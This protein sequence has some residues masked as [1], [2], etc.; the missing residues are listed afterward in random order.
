M[1]SNQTIRNSTKSMQKK[2][3]SK[4]SKKVNLVHKEVQKEARIAE[5]KKKLADL[6][7]EIKTDDKISADLKNLEADYA[8]IAFCKENFQHLEKEFQELDLE[9]QN[10][11]VSNTFIDFGKKLY[12]LDLDI[13]NN[14][15][16]KISEF[17]VKIL[18][19][20][21]E[22]KKAFL[23]YE[24]IKNLEKKYSS[25]K[26]ALKSSE[27]CIQLRNLEKK[28]LEFEFEFGNSLE[29]VATENFLNLK[30]K[31]SAEL[32]RLKNIEH[33]ADIFDCA[34]YQLEYALIEESLNNL[35][36]EELEKKLLALKVYLAEKKTVSSYTV[37]AK[38]AK[39][40]LFKSCKAISEKY[41]YMSDSEIDIN[42]GS[43]AYFTVEDFGAIRFV[44]ANPTTNAIINTNTIPEIPPPNRIAFTIQAGKG[45]G[46]GKYDLPTQ[47]KELDCLL[48]KDES[49][50]V[51]KGA[52]ITLPAG[53]L[54]AR[55]NSVNS[56]SFKESVS[57]VL[58]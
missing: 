58:D 7:L 24:N 42:L 49:F 6:E 31:V 39:K 13:H 5:L 21:F 55:K 32:I 50:F 23:F 43:N 12:K 19:F 41:D 18:N 37:N 53:T 3:A 17:D 15:T 45:I 4:H 29:A 25:F 20:E 54:I 34:L 56:F 22:L 1:S 36:F 30:I 9:M 48:A 44:L 51:G 47:S 10:L 11:S 2:D 35:S 28:V 8:K 57:I 38:L 40:Q 27:Y 16:I 33:K 46:V 52:C 26:P 14:F